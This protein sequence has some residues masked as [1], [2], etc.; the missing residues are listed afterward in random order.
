MKINDSRYKNFIYLNKETIFEDLFRDK[1]YPIVQLHDT[2]PCGDSIVGFCGTCSWINNELK[3]L[4]HDSY[5]SK[6]TVIAY[7]EFEHEDKVCLDIIVTDW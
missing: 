7:S 4:D 2:T 1:N 3:P 6:M 5:T